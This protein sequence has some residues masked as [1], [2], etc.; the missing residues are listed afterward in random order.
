[1]YS[2]LKKSPVLGTVIFSAAA[3]SMVGLLIFVGW[4]SYATAGKPSVDFYA[5]LG[6]LALQLAIVVI[7]GTFVKVIVDWGTS[8]RI[9]H[10][11]K[12]EAQK[13]FMK[14]VRAMHVSIQYA[15][16]LMNAHHT[17]KTWAE[18]SRRLMELRPEIEEIS[19]DL[20]ASKNLFEKQEAI[21]S[22]LE[23]IIKYLEEEKD[24]YVNHH[25]SVDNGFKNGKCLKETIAENKM[26][27][28]RDFMDGGDNY[29]N[30]YKENLTNLKGA[31]R[32]EIY[33]G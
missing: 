13:G 7:I 16:E 26:T 15:R 18:Q 30:S 2:K 28:V 31:M 24:E 11:E 8:Q 3:F 27:W 9:R 4:Q 33:G 19:E 29:S 14:R 17:A 22:G 12:L 6:E 32:S 21:I 23:E 25:E 5:K 1:M 20:K 10:T